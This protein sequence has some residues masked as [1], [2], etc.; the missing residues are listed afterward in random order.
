[1]A[2]P[3]EVLYSIP[4]HLHGRIHEEFYRQYGYWMQTYLK[5]SEEEYLFYKD[6]FPD[7]VRHTYFYGSAGFFW[8]PKELVK[9]QDH[10]FS[11]E[12]LDIIDCWVHR[13]RSIRNQLK[14]TMTG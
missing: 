6:T 8:V 7:V 2:T 9:N 10:Y 5:V 3:S 1:M 4:A 12:E 11:R 14:Q 13:N